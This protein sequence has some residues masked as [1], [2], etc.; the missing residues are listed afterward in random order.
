MRL[1]TLTA[2]SAVAF[3]GAAFGETQTLRMATIAPNLGAAITMA[4]FANI[5]ND[6]LEDIEIEVSGGGAATLH[7][8][9]VAR[10]NLELAMTS[11]VI[12]NLMSAGRAMYANEPEAPELAE[13]LRLLMWYPFGAYH[14]AVRADSD[15]QTLDD[16]EGASVFLGPQGGGAYNAARGWVASTTGLIAGEDFDAIVANWQTGWQAFLDGNIDVYVVG[17]LTPC[18][19][20]LQFTETEEVRFLGAESD[21]GDAVDEFLGAFRYKAEIVADGYAGQRNDGPVTSFDTAV[22]ITV[23][24]DLDEDTV[25]QIT[26]A[27]WDNLD[28]VTS[29]A[30]WAKALDVDFAATQR[31]LAQLHAG[32]ARYYREVGVI[33]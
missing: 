1:T 15:I 13:N 2:I 12:Y 4:T 28:Q 23:R 6:N 26:K 20:F 30:P 10:G 21:E 5:V 14:Y 18:G 3:S 9:E 29:D 7:Q 27:F 22:G 31:G 25:Y 16:L 17:C 11:P 33:E 19:A 24:A 32:A 8:V